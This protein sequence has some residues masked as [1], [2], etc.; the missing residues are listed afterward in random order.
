VETQD[1]LAGALADR[2]FI[3]REIGSGGMATV[4]LA[5]DLRHA[6][7]VA[8]KVLRSELAAALGP[9]R[10]LRE[11]RIAANLNHPHILPLYDSGEAD[12]FLYYVMPFEE[13]MSLRQKLAAE[14]E[15]PIPEV[16][17]ILRD[18]VDA[19]AHAHAKGVVHRDIKPANVMLSGR[20]A[21]VTDFG[22]A[23]AVSAATGPDRLTTAGVA[24][25][26]P[27]YMAPEQ[28]A[29][30]E[31]VDHRADIYAVGVVGYELL[32]GRPP[33]SGGTAQR[34]LAAQMTETPPDVTS[35]RESTPPEL[36]HIISKCLEKKP[37]DRWQDADQLL[38]RLEAL[39][40]PS[41]GVTP[42]ETPPVRPGWTRK[43]R[44]TTALAVGVASVAAALLFRPWTSDAPDPQRI[45][46]LAYADE[47]GLEG[48]RAL[49]RMA[50]DYIIQ[51]LSEAGFAEVVDP[52]TALAVAENVS[53]AGGATGFRDIL[54]LAEDARAGTVVSGTFY[55]QGDSVHIQTRI[56]N[57]SNGR[58]VGTVGPIV[59][60]LAA[61]NDL[62]ARVG[63]EVVAALAPLMNREVAEW[64]ARWPQPPAYEAFE[65]YSV[66][67]QAYL[68]A[69]SDQDFIAAGRHFERAFEA[70]STFLRAGI[71][72]AQS[73][74]VLDG[75][76]Y[77]RAESLIAMVAR[78]REELSRFDRCRLDFVMAMA[79]RRSLSA[80]HDAA[81]CMALA[82]PG[83]DD[84]R[85]EVAFFVSRSNR[86]REGIEMLEALDP[87]R[88]LMRRLKEY[89]RLL[90][91]AY[92][93]L[94]DHLGELEIA[95]RARERDPESIFLLGVETRALVALHR[96]DEV[97]ANL[98]GMRTLPS[99]DE[100]GI[101][102]AEVGEELRAHGH[103]DV[104]KGVFDDAIAWYQPRFP[105][106]EK[107]RAELAQLLYN[108]ERWDE[109][110][111]LYETLAREN[112]ENTIYLAG[113]GRLAA[114]RGDRGEALRISDAL[115]AGEN[116]R[117]ERIRT[118]DRARIAAL[119][120]DR[121]GATR[122]LQQAIE[123]G[124]GFGF[125]TWIHLDMDLEPLHDYP[126]YQEL[127]RPK[128]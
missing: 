84:A 96:L 63:R 55:V 110:T 89:W 36:A 43:K 35:L 82:A 7:Q 103:R 48:S 54:A 86:L 109:A 49:G 27:A 83:S 53:A 72:A 31:H 68:E 69:E 11:I 23:K 71:W 108:A 62:A 85:R 32:T 28:A 65:A 87:D 52:L 100:L 104:A 64:E 90:T 26:T 40:T 9:D 97:E 25:G 92:H 20:H 112:P 50:Q 3:G 29:G 45:L 57:A 114:R 51:S 93:Q 105:E 61:R 66:G 113:L 60:T 19:L 80:M 15:L 88:G 16:V 120:G 98:E 17:R 41:G 47:S 77:Q 73:Y 107:M 74:L 24:L 10:F 70:D 6:R 118:A 13:G 34:V 122:L 116:P 22:V 94:G 8:V 119:L 101:Y 126:P 58:L 125:G 59:G 18:I 95:R 76:A 12:G 99:R 78:H 4:Y 21:L 124:Y 30:D 37:A 56:T 33:F 1:R 39:A 81:R 128:G 2:Y 46:V 115:R 111:E 75:P 102:L 42:A 91:G 123:Q 5:E 38:I 44:V 79:P 117:T 127:M 106:S 14:G 121:E 67:L